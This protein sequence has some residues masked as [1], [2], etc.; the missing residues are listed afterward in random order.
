MAVPSRLNEYPVGIVIPATDLDTPTCSIFA[1]RRGSATS[2]DD[3]ET[4]SRYSRPRN[5]MSLKMLTRATSQSSE[6][7]TTTMKRAQ[8]M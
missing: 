6:P 7:S 2:L 4:M 8:V 3:V 1:M 5:F